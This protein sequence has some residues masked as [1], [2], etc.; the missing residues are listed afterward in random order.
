M[1]DTAVLELTDPRWAGFVAS[2]PAAT[3]FHHPHWG[4]LVAGCYGFRAFAVATTGPGGQIRAGLPVIEVRHLRGEPKW[5]SLPFTDYCPPLVRDGPDEAILAGALQQASTA[6]GI[7]RV[8]IRAP[9]AGAAPAGTAFR[10]VIALNGDADRVYARFRR[11]VRQQIRQAEQ[12]GVTVRRG[13]KP[14]DLT[15][16]F[17]RLHLRTR[18][19]LGVPVQP[20]RFF[21]MLWD[22]MIGPGLGLV[23]IA[24]A[25]GGPVAAQV[26]L[27][28]N[29]TMI[30]K[31]SA[32]DD[33]AWSLR[34]NDLIVWHSIQTAFERGC[35]RLDMGRTDAANEGLRA[36]KRS[37]GSVEEPLVYGS[38]GVGPEPATPGNGRA[39]HVLAS[40]IRRGPLALCRATGEALYR[41]AA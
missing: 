37:W 21:R 19:R 39:G 24:E 36:F 16:V 41:Y 20:R 12:R 38:L 22:S 30:G 29:G 4:T 6:A 5:V 7:Q 40:V 25:A 26:C 27:A 10:H 1:S 13:T 8:V 33:R 28:W 32:S 11:A 2:Q 9:L 3:P 15:E 31:F 34:P 35:R 17:Y 14:E 23:F 18:R